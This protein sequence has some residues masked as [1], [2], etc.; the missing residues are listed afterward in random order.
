[1]K[2]QIGQIVENVIQ[3]NRGEERI[4]C[5]VLGFIDAVGMYR[6]TDARQT[7]STATLI[8]KNLTWA[9][10]M[11]NIR[12]HDADCIECHKNGLVKFA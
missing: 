6:L 7:E 12:T 3:T 11:E 8:E 5:R 4:V 10:P 2:L 1:M 9:A